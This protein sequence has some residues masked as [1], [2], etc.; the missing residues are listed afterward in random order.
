MI[1]KRFHSFSYLLSNSDSYIFLN[2]INHSVVII[3]VDIGYHNCTLTLMDS[4][5]CDKIIAFSVTPQLLLCVF[6]CIFH[7]RFLY[8]F[9]CVRP[10]RALMAGSNDFY[11][12]V[13]RVPKKKYF[14]SFIIWL[15]FSFSL[16]F[17]NFVG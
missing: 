3:D 11:D 17:R 16:C 6:K 9:F 13:F 8:F 5:R 7:F 15:I 10:H 2:V 12:N 4:S 14:D 1:T